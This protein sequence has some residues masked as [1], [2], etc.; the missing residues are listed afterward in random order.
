MRS[1]KL[2]LLTT[3]AVAALSSAAYAADLIVDVPIADPIIDNSFS[4][5]GAYIGAFIQGQTAPGAFGIGADL[6][7]NAVMDGLLLGGELSGYVGTG[8]TASIQGTVK[9]GA[10]MDSAAFYVYSGLGTAHPTSYY[11][12]VGVGAEV[13]VADN[14]TIKGEVQYQWDLTGDPGNIAA[15]VGVNFHF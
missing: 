9:V 8:I 13:A 15:R 14:V 11:V 4:F 3:A 1:F 12:P 2:A 7:V 6:G 10:A 5:D